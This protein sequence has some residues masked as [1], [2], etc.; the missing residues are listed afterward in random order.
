MHVRDGASAD[1]DLREA[2]RTQTEALGPGGAGRAR[3]CS[4]ATGAARTCSTS[5]TTTRA[6]LEDALGVPA[7][8]LLLR[9]RDRAGR[10]PQLPARL[11]G[12]DGRLPWASRWPAESRAGARVAATGAATRRRALAEDLGAGDV[13]SEATVPAAAA[14]P[15]PD[16]AEAARRRVRARRRRRGLSPGG[17]RRVRAADDRGPSGAT[18]SRPTSRWSAARPGRCSPPSAPRSTC[19]ATCPGSRPSTARYVDA[20]ARQRVRVILDTRKT[21]PGLRALEKARGRRRRRAQPS[22]GPRRRDPDQGEP[23]RDRRRGRP[24]G[25][26]RRATPTPSSRSRSSAAT[27][28]RSPRRS[29]AGADRLLLDNMDDGRAAGRG[30]RPRRRGRS[31]ASARG[32]RGGHPRQRRRDR[33]HR[34]RAA[35]RSARSPT[36][37]RRSTSACCSSP[38]ERLPARAAPD[39]VGGG[40]S[41]RG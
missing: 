29:A 14:R 35:S 33:R 12:D 17:R 28:T 34:R 41:N 25:R 18:R 27:P 39:I 11:H 6:A 3:C 26:A 10:R 21:T 20:I 36:R 9:R 24:R 1:E 7:G 37:R 23:R 16:R 19:S 8:G 4:P 13:T 40:G 22:H 31:A 32:L 5:P 38:P 30:R 2:L 15:R